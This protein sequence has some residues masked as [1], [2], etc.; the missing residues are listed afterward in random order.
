[1]ERYSC[2]R[3]TTFTLALLSAIFASSYGQEDMLDRIGAE[4]EVASLKGAEKRMEAI[5]ATLDGVVRVAPPP[6]KSENDFL[7]KKAEK[8]NSR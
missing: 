3:K 8:K 7:P 6:T 5:E 2:N 1:M 4:S